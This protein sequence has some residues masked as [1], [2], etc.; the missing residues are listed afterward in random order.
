MLYFILFY[1]DIIIYYLIMLIIIFI[2]FIYFYYFYY[3]ITFDCFIDYLTVT[4]I[5]YSMA[6]IID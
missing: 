4:I 3:S 5:D 1:Y 6:I 2:Y